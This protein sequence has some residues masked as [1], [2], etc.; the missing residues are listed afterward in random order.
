MG[1]GMCAGGGLW[2]G[3]SLIFRSHRIKPREGLPIKP[4]EKSRARNWKWLPQGGRQAEHPP[5]ALG[6]QG[7]IELFHSSGQPSDLLENGGG[8]VGLPS[9]ADCLEVERRVRR[10]L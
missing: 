6:A 10:P 1:G 2:T 9:S 5:R 7:R 8:G 3:S 4:R